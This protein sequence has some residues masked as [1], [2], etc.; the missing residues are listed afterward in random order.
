MTRAKL[1]KRVERAAMRRQRTAVDMF[2]DWH[3][4]EHAEGCT[5][6]EDGY[7][8]RQLRNA[9]VAGFKA[10]AALAAHDRKVKR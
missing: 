5:V 4:R 2:Y 1:S 8:R 6:I 7:S 3:A 10:H 9:Y